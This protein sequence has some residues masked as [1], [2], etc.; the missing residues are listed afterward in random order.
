MRCVG[1]GFGDFKLFLMGYGLPLVLEV[2]E[3][4]AVSMSLWPVDHVC[5]V[6]AMSPVNLYFFLVVFA[7]FYLSKQAGLTDDAQ[8]G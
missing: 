1:A 2:V 6:F 8:V 4:V 3:N 7:T 5:I